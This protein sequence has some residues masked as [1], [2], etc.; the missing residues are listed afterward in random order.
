[1]EAKYL[2]SPPDLPISWKGLR[3]TPYKNYL[4]IA[5]C[6]FVLVLCFPLATFAQNAPDGPGEVPTWTSGAKE[7]VGTSTSIDSKVWF[8]LQGGI[9]TEVYYPK[10]DT[11]NV[12]TLEFAVTDGLRVWVESKDM[13]HSLERINDDALLYRQNSSDPQGKFKISKTYATDPKNNSLLIDISFSGPA[14]FSLY[15][16][17]DPALK[18][19]G[20]GDTGYSQG[21]ALI[22]QK[23]NVAAALVSAPGFT[24]TSSGFAGTTS[25]PYADLLRH[26]AL[27]Q[28]Y[29]RAENGN[30]LQAAK[31]PAAKHIVIALAFGSNPAAAVDTATASLR[32]S[33]SVISAGYAAGWEGYVSGLVRVNPQYEKLFELS[34]M[35]LKAHEDKTYRGAMIA[36][37]SVPWGFAV[38]AS[39]PIVGGYHLVWARDL[40]EIATGLLAAGDRGA[41][42]RALNYLFTVQQE[43]NG[44]YPQNSWL[45]GQP[46]WT[47]LQ[48]DEVSYPLILAWQLGRMDAETWTK[49]VRPSAEFIVSHGPAT[50]QDRWEE[51]S[52][53]SPSTIAT[54]IAGLVCASDIAR[55]NAANAEAQYYL[56][57]ADEWAANLDKWTVTTT[58]H[59]D[60]KNSTRGYYIRIDNTTDPN[61][62]ARLDVRNGGGVWDKRDIVDAGFLELVRLGI[63]PANDA[64]ISHSVEVIDSTIRVETPN[65]PAF[66]RYNHDGYGE[67]YYGGPWLGEGIG[68]LWPI[69][70]GERGEYEIALGHDPTPYL[71]SMQQFANAGG[72]IPE[73][74]WDRA[75]PTVKRFNFGSGTDGATPLA[76]SMAQFLRLAVCAEQKRI[77]ET[78]SIVADHFRSTQK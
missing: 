34:A 48:M 25:D 30:V 71:V 21:D 50:E 22:T 24:E 62:G 53:Y 8:T 9:L 1:M 52:G 74:V 35:T 41:A 56:R 19:S 13:L 37:M 36:S 78:P 11:A 68:R 7:A 47:G 3:V 26:D 76:W 23:E 28:K 70:T 32:K 39:E 18:N 40:Y 44:R 14:G 59:L 51:V 75:D 10:L 46:Y 60:K 12:R 27:T 77:V 15:L 73:Q 42:D 31:L 54:E 20:Y 45:D 29:A 64:V 65:G 67:T 4:A 69:F 5:A 16:L 6:I 38:K 43:P 55:R 49:H 58:G 57:V 66:R 33:F 61:D 63:R 72:M 2:V 17:F